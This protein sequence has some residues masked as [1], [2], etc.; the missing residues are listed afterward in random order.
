MSILRKTEAEGMDG[1]AHQIR[2]RQ[3]RTERVGVPLG[4]DGG[5]WAAGLH[6][7]GA[8]TAHGAPFPIRG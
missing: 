3:T 8:P 6:P 1:A 7:N 4:T 2:E 5:P